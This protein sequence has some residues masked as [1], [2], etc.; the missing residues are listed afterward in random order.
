MDTTMAAEHTLPQSLPPR[1]RAKEV[2]CIIATAIARSYS[3]VPAES[4]VP[5][6]FSPGKSVHD[7]SSLP[8]VEQ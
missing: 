1:E 2:A 6:G 5:L 4:E 8:G 7:N 3:A